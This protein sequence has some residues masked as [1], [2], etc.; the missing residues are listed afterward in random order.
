MAQRHFA[1]LENDHGHQFMYGSI[2]RPTIEEALWRHNTCW[3]D[4][5][6]CAEGWH[7]APL[8]VIETREKSDGEWRAVDVRKF[9]LPSDVVERSYTRALT[10]GDV[11]AV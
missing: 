6:F 8:L 5:P 9:Q 11:T 1:L 7:D 2:V 4:A 3:H 10:P